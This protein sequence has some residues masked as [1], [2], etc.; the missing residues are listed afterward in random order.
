MNRGSSGRRAVRGGLFVSSRR[1]VLRAS[2]P[3]FSRSLSSPDRSAVRRRRGRDG[4]ALLGRARR[5]RRRVC[6][7]GRSVRRR[8]PH[9]GAGRRA[10]GARLDS[11]A[12]AAGICRVCARRSARGR[13]VIA[14][15]ED[16]PG[17]YH[18]VVV[19]S[20]RRGGP[21]VLHDPA[22]APVARHGRARPSTRAGPEV[23]SL[24]AG[25]ASPAE[26]TGVR[27]PIF[28][29]ERLRSPRLTQR[30]AR[31]KITDLT[32]VPSRGVGRGGRGGRACAARGQGRRRGARSRRP[33][34]VSGRRGAVAGTRRTRRAGGELDD[35]A[36]TRGGPWQTD[37]RRRARV[38]RPRHRRVSPPSTI[39]RRSPRGTA[40][41][42]PRADLVDIKGLDHTRYL[43]IADAI[44]VGPRQLLTPDAL[45]ARAAARARR[46]RRSR[47]RA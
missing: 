32:P 25:A 23:R 40:I 8:H 1:A 11:R 30:V 17:R 29:R 18:Y 19:V 47:P 5:L 22:R 31:S 34:R 43:V 13:P 26:D 4:D 44:G 3:A 35:A 16:R 21:I 14:L 15:I 10:R 7:A 42:E 24:D 45:R 9:V 36:R 33:R 46:A 2:A 41:G 37:P 39:S 6:A 28:S 20:A 12:R 38:A 27:S